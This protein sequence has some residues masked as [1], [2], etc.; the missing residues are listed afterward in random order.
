VKTTLRT[1]AQRA[2]NLS[3]PVDVAEL[4]AH[5]AERGT[6]AYVLTGGD[7]GR[8]H[9]VS[10]R[11]TRTGDRFEC[12]AGNRTAANAVARPLVSL[13]WPARDDDD[14]SLIVDGDAQVHTVD[15]EQRL[16]VT[17]TRAVLHR[18]VPAA[19]GVRGANDCVSL[20]AASFDASQVG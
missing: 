8:P 17:A 3:V 1:Q 15:G 20:D 5:V 12:G 14:Y 10:V 18:T 11:V 2:G 16:V 19:A 6:L 9:A 7:D 4:G 13:L